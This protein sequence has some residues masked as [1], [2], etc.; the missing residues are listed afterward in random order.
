MGDVLS[1]RPSNAE[2]V[3]LDEN[4]IRW[5]DFCRNNIKELKI[6]NKHEIQE[7]IILR[8]ILILIGLMIAVTSIGFGNFI[9]FMI[10]FLIGG[11][12]VVIGSLSI[13][14]MYREKQHA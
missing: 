11:S 13:L 14:K 9:L 4:N 3:I 12:L 6:N 10:E 2:K 8:A 7:K 1:Y 5:N